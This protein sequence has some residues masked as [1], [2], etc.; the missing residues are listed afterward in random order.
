MSWNKSGP[1]AATYRGS[2]KAAPPPPPGGV[3]PPPPPPT[4]AQF[5][6]LEIS[7]KPKPKA[8]GDVDQLFASLNQA[9]R[10][11]SSS[12]WDEIDH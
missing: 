6:K 8:S 9:Q 4:L 7:S 1:D 3:P 11:E 10:G 2:G 5:E 12:F